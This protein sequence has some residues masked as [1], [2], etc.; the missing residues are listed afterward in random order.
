MYRL[1]NAIQIGELIE[2]SRTVLKRQGKKHNRAV[3][4]L[5]RSAEFHGVVIRHHSDGRVTVGDQVA[6]VITFDWDSG[7]VRECYGSTAFN[8]LET[9]RKNMILDDLAD[10]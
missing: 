10:V 5:I 8:V 2:R 3:T 4:G 7:G 9:L 1:T 6:G